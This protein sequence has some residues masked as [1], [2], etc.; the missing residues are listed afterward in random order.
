MKN[1]VK[2]N[3]KLFV[4][5]QDAALRVDFIETKSELR[6]YRRSVYEALEWADKIDER[7]AMEKR[8]RDELKRKEKLQRIRDMRQL[9][10][11]EAEEDRKEEEELSE[12]ERW[13][14]CCE[15]V[16]H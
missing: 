2:L 4:K 6:A 8:Q 5:A 13:D 9:R 3:P 1:K 10:E 7:I 11:N 15:I 16:S 14:I 12:K